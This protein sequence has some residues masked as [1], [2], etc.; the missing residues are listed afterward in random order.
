MYSLTPCDIIV[1]IYGAV[2]IIAS[3]VRTSYTNFYYYKRGV[4][5]PA[6]TLLCSQVRSYDM[7]MRNWKSNKKGKNCAKSGPVVDFQDGNM[8]SAILEI[9]QTDE[10]I[11][12]SV[13]IAESGDCQQ[14]YISANTRHIIMLFVSKYT[15]L[16]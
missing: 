12:N 1:Y 6:T 7:T 14:V 4:G 10:D 15:F 11:V 3:T 2:K 8:R 9:M 5:L 13:V 16:R